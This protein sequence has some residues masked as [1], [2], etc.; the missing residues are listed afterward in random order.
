MPHQLG[1][2]PDENTSM[3]D[4]IKYYSKDKDLVSKLNA[5]SLQ[6]GAS[7]TNVTT[8]FSN[9]G[10]LGQF[11]QP[12]MA[13]MEDVYKIDEPTPR[14][15]DINLGRMALKFFTDM[16]VAAGKPG[17]TVLSSG[18]TAGQSLA[19]D[20][21]NRALIK[22]QTKKKTKQAQKAG[23]V[24]LA[25]QLKSAQDAKDLA[26]AKLKPKVVTLYKMPDNKKA[27]AKTMQVIEGGA[28]YLNLTAK[29]GGYSVDKPDF[30]TV[31]EN[32]FG[33]KVYV[34]GIYDGRLFKDVQN[35]NKIDNNEN[36][37]TETE[38][39]DGS[40]VSTKPNLMRLTK[41]QHSQA[42]DFRKTIMDQTKDFRQDIQP[43]YLKIIQFYNNRDPIGDYSLAVGY[44]KMIDPGSVAREGEVSAV[45]NSGSIP[46]TLKAQLLNALTGNGRLP[47]R[48]RAG[49]YNR[50]IEIF[51]TERKKA[52]EIIDAVNKSWSAQIGRND[53]IDH[54]LH[55]KIEP[56]SELEK[57][58]LSKIPLEKE[59][60]FK[61]ENIEKMTVQE[62]I[63]V[64]SFQELTKPQLEFISNLIQKKKQA[65][66]KDK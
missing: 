23:A 38:N 59:F 34:G 17:A 56:E 50:A 1:H 62:L 48:V 30:G 19:Q 21:L 63:D 15:K 39:D 12:A 58:D 36:V 49:I 14:E 47:Q 28:E 51:N 40:I 20:Y 57:V 5:Q 41:A 10:T 27:G 2:L 9:M 61:E 42:K 25:M 64:I 53:Q 37:D 46:D 32:D 22:E 66:K 35:E 6:S 13:I 44:A 60:V 65:R 7:G 52:L 18:V 11:M 55:Y 24:S 43:G 16:S 45:A 33:D 26:L 4:L 54:I 29:G 8:D 3:E 31:T